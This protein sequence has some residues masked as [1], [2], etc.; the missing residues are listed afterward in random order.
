M[1]THDSFTT[2][3][4]RDEWEKFIADLDNPK[5]RPLNSKL[6]E[7]LKAAKENETMARYTLTAYYNTNTVLDT[8]LANDFPEVEITTGTDLWDRASITVDTIA[9]R[10][11]Y[12]TALW[13]YGP[14]TVNTYKE[15]RA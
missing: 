10:N 6:I 8:D 2:Y 15:T 14:H 9:K 13:S 5:P 12:F 7:I 11:V 4:S 3:L 1:S